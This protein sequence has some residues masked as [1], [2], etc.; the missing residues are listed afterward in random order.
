MRHSWALDPE[1]I[2]V[3]NELE[4]DS[5]LPLDVL[6]ASS[7]PLCPLG[8]SQLLSSGHFSDQAKKKRL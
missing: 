3:G 2:H 6:G 5:W 4:N 1:E 7:A 8:A